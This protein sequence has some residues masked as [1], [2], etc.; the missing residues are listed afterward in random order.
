MTSP[1][2]DCFQWAEPHRDHSSCSDLPVAC[3]VDD[4]K[5]LGCLRTEGQ[6]H[7]TSWCQLVQQSSWRH[8]GSGCDQNLGKG[9]M[10]GPAPGAVSHPNGDVPIAQLLQAGLCMAGELLNH[11]DGPHLAG[12]FSKNRSLVA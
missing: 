2:D 6:H 1:S 3:L 5:L 9:G 8:L 11:L 10:L 7:A 4:R 12:E